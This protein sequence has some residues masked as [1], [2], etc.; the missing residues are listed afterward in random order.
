M[1]L[2]LASKEIFP[3]VHPKYP[4]ELI[5]HNWITQSYTTKHRQR[6]WV[7]HDSYLEWKMWLS[8]LWHMIGGKM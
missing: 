3:R 8:P 5:S 2:F 4:S 6:E 1:Y 7:Y